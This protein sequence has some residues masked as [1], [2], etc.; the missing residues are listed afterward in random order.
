[1]PSIVST[2][3]SLFRFSALSAIRSVI[4]IDMSSS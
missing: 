4:K 2:V 3:R 1:M